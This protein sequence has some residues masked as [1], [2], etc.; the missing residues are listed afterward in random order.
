MIQ[1]VEV[2]SKKQLKIFAALP[3]KLYKG[4]PY[5]VP[6]MRDD[7][8]SILNPKKNFNLGHCDCKCFLAYK[9]GKPVG[10][11]AGIINKKA[12]EIY[13]HKYI[14]FAR[15]AAI[16][17][18]EVFRALINAVEEYGKSE[19]L[20]SIHGPWGFNDTDRDGM[21]TYG[22]DKRSTYSTEYS[23]PYYM[24]RMVELGFKD[25]SKWIERDFVIPTKP[26]EKIERIAEKLK[27]RYNLIDVTETMTINQIVKK[28]GDD[29]FK[30]YNQAYSVLDEYVPIEG[31]AQK[32]VLNQF[33]TVINTRYAS[34]L[35]NEDDQVVGFGLTIPSLADALIKSKGKLFPFGFIGVLKSIKKPKELEMVLI[36]VR[37]EYKN[38]GIN[39]ICMSK[40]M[41]NVIKDGIKKIESNPMLETNLSIQANW[42]FAE[43][44]IIKKR[45][46]YSK[47]IV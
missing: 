6:S 3:I 36:G 30:A 22:F 37:D 13:N 2:K 1:I 15:L 4:C 40:I 31:D 16:D 8:F 41:N 11:I 38:S 18:I 19:G 26:Y 21:L 27:K 20:S 43:N 7:D 12:N 45:Q 14:R 28:Y 5:Y 39:S 34:I 29:F 46:T 24:E 47:E 23:Y 32:S 35:V 44:T 42:N 17:D 33:A 9:D 25:E 10:R